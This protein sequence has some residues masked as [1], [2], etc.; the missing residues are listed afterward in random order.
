MRS[1]SPSRCVHAARDWRGGENTK[2]NCCATKAL[3]PGEA[4][5]GDLRVAQY[6]ASGSLCAGWSRVFGLLLRTDL[7]L[8]AH[9]KTQALWLIFQGDDH[10]EDHIAAYGG[11][12]W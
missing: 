3:A 4:W 9:A 1:V 5:T 8:Q 12:W 2:V 7:Y 11:A 6:L 10:A